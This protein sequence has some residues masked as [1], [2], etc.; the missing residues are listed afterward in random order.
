[1]DLHHHLFSTAEVFSS[2]YVNTFKTDI[3]S[4]NTK[5]SLV[6]LHLQTEQFIHKLMKASKSSGKK[7]KGCPKLSLELHPLSVCLCSAGFHEW[8]SA[9]SLRQNLV[10]CSGCAEISS[11]LEVPESL[12]GTVTLR[13]GPQLVLLKVRGQHRQLWLF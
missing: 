10:N 7:H 11:V 4:K 12:R 1:M 5:P 2:K 9:G 6:H 3:L 8:W 13:R